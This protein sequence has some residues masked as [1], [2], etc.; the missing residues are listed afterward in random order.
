M[1]D[2]TPQQMEFL[3]VRWYKPVVQVSTWESSTLDQVKFLPLND[4]HSFDFVDPADILRGCHI[5]PCFAKRK[6]HPDGSGV[7]TC[8]G[9]KNDWLEY[10]MNR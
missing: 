8:A 7:S 6:K 2:Y 5:I 3:W 10:Y 1:I 9:D 4:E